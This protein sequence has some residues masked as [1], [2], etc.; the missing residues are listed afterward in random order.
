MDARHFFSTTVDI[1]GA[2]PES[3][4]RVARGMIETTMIPAQ[5]NVPYNELL[6]AHSHDEAPG[7]GGQESFEQPRVGRAGEAPVG[8]RVF[9][10][11][12]GS[13]RSALSGAR[14]K[15]PS[16][17]IADLMA[18][19]TPPLKYSTIR[20]GPTGACLDMLCFGACKEPDCT[21]KHPTARISIDPARAAA[22]ATK[23]KAG[24]A[25]YEATNPTG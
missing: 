11:V 19:T 7:A 5:M 10:R 15:Y 23:L 25:A 1:T 2:L 18:A 14:V 21:Y 9:S 6:G 22:A 16:I 8:Q 12:P 4:L 20:V 3:N 13:L 17:R 24:L